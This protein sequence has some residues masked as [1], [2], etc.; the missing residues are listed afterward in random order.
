[1][2]WISLPPSMSMALSETRRF[3]NFQGLVTLSIFTEKHAGRRD[4]LGLGIHLLDV[5]PKLQRFILASL[6]VP[7]VSLA[8]SLRFGGR[9]GLDFEFQLPSGE[10]AQR[11]VKLD[12]PR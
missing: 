8:R 9:F 7:P 4:R 6:S 2:N 1:L 12:E 3:S 5:D 11:G 10:L